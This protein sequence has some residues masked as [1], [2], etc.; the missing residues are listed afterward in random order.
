MISWVPHGEGWGA[1]MQTMREWGNGR[2]LKGNAHFMVTTGLMPRRLHPAGDERGGDG[3]R[4][5][6]GYEAH[7]K[8]RL[9]SAGPKVQRC[10]RCH[11]RWAIARREEAS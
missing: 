8:T 7:A 1:W 10:H 4:A 2:Y 3:L 9:I 5:L 11:V 6:C